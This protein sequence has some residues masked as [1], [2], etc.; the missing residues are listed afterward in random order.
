MLLWRCNL[1]IFIGLHHATPAFALRSRSGQIAT[2]VTKMLPSRTT[3]Y[4]IGWTMVGRGEGGWLPR[5]GV[6]G[7]HA[8]MSLIDEI[9][10]LAQQVADCPNDEIADLAMD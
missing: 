2:S 3:H 5:Q 8:I 1:L 4:N 7:I 6:F 9:R 10:T